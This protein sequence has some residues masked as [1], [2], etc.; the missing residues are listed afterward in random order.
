MLPMMMSGMAAGMLAA[1]EASS[2]RC[3]RGGAAARGAV[4]GVVMLAATYAVNGYLQ[5]KGSKW[6][7]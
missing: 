4:V 6:T 3:T 7:S 1:M 5:R 2:A